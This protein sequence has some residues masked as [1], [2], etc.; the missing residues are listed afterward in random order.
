M[1]P[2]DVPEA[3]VFTRAELDELARAYGQPARRPTFT[4]DGESEQDE[5]DDESE[6]G[7]D[8][9]RFLVIQ[10]AAAKSCH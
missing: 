6:E 7:D 8:V 10:M 5:E 4:L 3:S 9:R 2:M 1:Y